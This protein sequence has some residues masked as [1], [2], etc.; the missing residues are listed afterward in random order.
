MKHLSFIL[1]FAAVSLAQTPNI[2]VVV[3]SSYDSINPRVRTYGLWYGSTH[4]FNDPTMP[5]AVYIHGGEWAGGSAFSKIGVYNPISPGTCQGPM[6]NT[7]ICALAALGYA[8][9]SINYTLTQT[10]NPATTWPVQWQ[11]CECFLKFLAEQAG[12]TV[13]GNP[14]KIYLFGH[15]A[16]AH[17][18]G[19]TAL[20]P[21]NTFPTNC[22]HKST[23]YK[24][25]ALV[26]ASPPL[27]LHDE[28]VAN[29]LVSGAI[30]ALLG[31]DAGAGAD[32]S[33][34]AI[35][36][37]ADP[38]TYVSE[39]QP[40]TTVET[41]EAD[42]EI[43]YNLQGALKNAYSQLNPP[44]SSVWNVYSGLNHDLD[45]FYYQP[46]SLDPGGEP[47]PCGASGSVFMDL[48]DFFQKSTK[49]TR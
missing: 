45:L 6:T 26:L 13:P 3:G 18:A 27:N 33:C 5:I 19:V 42:Q 1:V 12:V 40:P 24:I 43:P 8:V 23:N 32:S 41:G 2:K 36:A 4:P 10:G 35:A 22:H 16:G 14:S 37:S 28:A 46:C 29:P 39:S 31:C 21:H 48:T 17:L 25:Q 20:A 44:V 9:Y 7:A 15:S 38:V 34:L 30:S 11:D 49:R 47:S